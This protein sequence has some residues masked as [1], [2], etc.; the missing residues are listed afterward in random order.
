M[1]TAPAIEVA[2]KGFLFGHDMEWM[3]NWTLA[4]GP[5]WDPKRPNFFVQDPAWSPD[6]APNGTLVKRGELIYRKRY[7]KTLRAIAAS[8][9][10]QFYTGAIAQSMIQ[11]IQRNKGNMTESDLKNY[12]VFHRTP[13]Q[14]QY[15]GYNVTSTV[16]PSSGTVLLNILSVLNNYKDFFRTSD[17]TNIST[18]RMVEAMK[19]GYSYVCRWS[20][21]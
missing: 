12:K 4:N 3:V 15:R 17:R 9:G 6:F 20:R 8:N 11:T 1:V 2:E 7:A 13:R 19:F 16:A 18:H 10:T 14:V 21:S 5:V